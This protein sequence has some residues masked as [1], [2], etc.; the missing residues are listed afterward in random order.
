ME[1][2]AHGLKAI[3]HW[4]HGRTFC[5]THAFTSPQDHLPGISPWSFVLSS[6]NWLC[7]WYLRILL[8]LSMTLTLD[9]F[10]CAGYILDFWH[11]FRR[12]STES[13][14]HP[15]IATQHFMW[16]VLCQYLYYWTKYWTSFLCVYCNA[17]SYQNTSV[18][19]R[20]CTY[21]LKNLCIWWILWIITKYIYSYNQV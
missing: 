18:L 17:H 21:T 11:W 2:N 16:F 14:V 5:S 9:L 12:T 7:P 20:Y 1:T 19:I 4:A 8:S 13:V 3:H 6:L 10:C 15:D